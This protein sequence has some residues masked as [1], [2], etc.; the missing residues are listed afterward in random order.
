MVVQ[1]KKVYNKCAG[2]MPGPLVA[3]GDDN[4]EQQK[5]VIHCTS[6]VDGGQDMH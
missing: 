1:N 6:Y 5:E 2:M 4:E 3:R